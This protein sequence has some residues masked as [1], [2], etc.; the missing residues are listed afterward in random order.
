MGN[1]KRSY[2]VLC[3]GE[4][5]FSIFNIIFLIN[6]KIRHIED[7]RG[8]KYSTV[9]KKNWNLTQLVLKFAINFR[10]FYTFATINLAVS[11]KETV[12]VKQ[13]IIKVK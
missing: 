2:Q 13:L 6:A 11:V 8:R 4:T 10:K 5:A 1:S 3:V 7:L 9:E 12:N